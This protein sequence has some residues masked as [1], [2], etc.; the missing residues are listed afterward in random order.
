MNKKEIVIL[1][2]GVLAILAVSSHFNEQSKK[3]ADWYKAIV[4]VSESI[5]SRCPAMLSDDIRLDAVEAGTDRRLTYHCT[6]MHVRAHEI[7]VSSFKDRLRPGIVGH[8]GSNPEMQVV[9]DHQVELLYVYKDKDGTEAF[10]IFV[11]PKDY[12]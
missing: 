6:L 4:Q 9:R 3:K 5:N 12:L 2:A 1:V 8:A 10:R 7:D 11:S